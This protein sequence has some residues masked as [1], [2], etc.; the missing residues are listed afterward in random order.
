[1]VFALSIRKSSVRQKEMLWQ[2]SHRA[3]LGADMPV[4]EYASNGQLALF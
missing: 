4:P 1:M 2:M 3:E